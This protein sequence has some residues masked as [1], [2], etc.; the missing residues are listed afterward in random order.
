MYYKYFRIIVITLCYGP[1]ERKE[2]R[3]LLEST[4][5]K[6]EE[7]TTLQQKGL[8]IPYAG[9]TPYGAIKET[10]NEG[11]IPRIQTET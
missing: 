8:L 1:A 4:K 9:L 5:S 3:K 10:R 7:R 11:G 2:I 6:G